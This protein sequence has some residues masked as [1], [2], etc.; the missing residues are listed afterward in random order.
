MTLN[1]N[2]ILDSTKKIL[3]LAADYDVFDLDVIIHINTA[4]TTLTEIGVGPADG[5]FISDSDDTWSDFLGGDARL[6]AVKTYIYLRVRL[7]FD[8][9]ASSFALTSMERQLQ[10]MEW[11]LMV[12]VDKPPAS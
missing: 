11:R 8:P 2:S 7:L 5:F 12:V 6:N 4:L 9:P 10:E 1:P 3:G